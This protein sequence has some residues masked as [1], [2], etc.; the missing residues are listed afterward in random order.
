MTSVP[1]TLDNA[2]TERRQRTVPIRWVLVAMLYALAAKDI[3]ICLADWTRATETR[4]ALIS[5]DAVALAPLMHILLAAMAIATG[6]IVWTRSMAPGNH[7]PLKSLFSPQF[8]VL[9]F[10]IMPVVLCLILISK[11]ELVEVQTIVPDP[12][13]VRIEQPDTPPQ[14][15]SRGA[16][17]LGVPT[18]NE[19]ALWVFAAFLIYLAWDFVGDIFMRVRR[20]AAAWCLRLAASF[21]CAVMAWFVWR[22]VDATELPPS[23]VIAADVVLIGLFIAFHALKSVEARVLT[24]VVPSAAPSPT[25]VP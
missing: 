16:V 6:W 15:V 17:A 11:I 24:R 3:A 4:E 2:G 10:E 18:A 22:A 12:A 20:D 13:A 25:A 14:L 1:D 21:A 23:T 8:V 7:Q 5:L 19:E 9:M